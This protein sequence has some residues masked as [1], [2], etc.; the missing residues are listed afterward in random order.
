M[1]KCT[2]TETDCDPPCPFDGSCVTQTVW[3]EATTL[4]NDYLSSLTLKTLCERGQ[5]M[6]LKRESNHKFMYYI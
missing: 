3:H 5:A 2:C 1:V 4:L 6:G